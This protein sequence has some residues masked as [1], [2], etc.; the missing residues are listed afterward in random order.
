MVKYDESKFDDVCLFLIKK[1]EEDR[2]FVVKE[3]D[4]IKMFEIDWDEWYGMKGDVM[5]ELYEVGI[6]VRF[7]RLRDYWDNLCSY[8]IVE[9]VRCI[10]VV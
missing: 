8:V 7:K 3:V 2:E 5:R 4:L 10:E 6:I 1:L 9:D